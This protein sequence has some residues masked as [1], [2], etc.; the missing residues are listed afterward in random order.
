LL[1]AISLC[2]LIFVAVAAFPFLASLYPSSVVGSRYLEVQIFEIP[3][4]SYKVVEWNN[5]P[6]AIVRPSPEML[7][8]LKENTS[9]TWSSLPIGGDEKVFVIAIVSTYKKC[10][11][12]HE[13]KAS[14]RFAEDVHWPGGFVDPC[15]FGEWDYAGRALKLYPKM[16]GHMRLDDLAVPR[17]E[18]IRDG[19]VIRLLP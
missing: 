4:G 7:K 2:G 5:L 11:L 13:G 16:E 19:T 14:N 10:G 18:L 8:H 17:Y 15:H 1:L 9:R 6:I 12:Q 3:L